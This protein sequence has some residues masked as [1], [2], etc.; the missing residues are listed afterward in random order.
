MQESLT[1]EAKQRGSKWGLLT[2]GGQYFLKKQG[3]AEG[4]LLGKRIRTEKLQPGKEALFCLSQFKQDN[5][6]NFER[7]RGILGEEPCEG[8]LYS[9]ISQ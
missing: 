1:C 3:V 4:F 8:T 9:H 2:I 7:E 5:M 6:D